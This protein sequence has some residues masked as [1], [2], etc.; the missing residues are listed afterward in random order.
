MEQES[1]L[2]HLY[3]TMTKNMTGF[4]ITIEESA[5]IHI[6]FSILR[7]WG[8]PMAQVNCICTLPSY[9]GGVVQFAHNLLKMFPSNSNAILPT[10]LI[11]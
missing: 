5:D 1:Q 10:M 2:R 9:A 11:K 3:Q 8:R 4:E 6:G 7:P